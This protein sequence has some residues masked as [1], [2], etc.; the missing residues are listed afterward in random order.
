MLCAHFTGHDDHAPC[1]RCDACADEAGVEA[2]LAEAPARAAVGPRAPRTTRTTRPPRERKP[3]AERAGRGARRSIATS[4]LARSLDRFRRGKARELKWK[5][6]MVFQQKVI[7]A[8]D[9]QRPTTHAELARIPGL[10]VSRIQRFGDELIAL[11]RRHG[12]R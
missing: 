1:E 7:V 4:E 11:V 2:M 5:A 3:R 10:G 9:A 6:Y 12:E 8:I